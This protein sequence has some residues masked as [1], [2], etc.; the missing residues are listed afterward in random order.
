MKHFLTKILCGAAIMMAGTLCADAAEKAVVVISTDGTQRQET[1]ANVD[2]IE[3]GVNSLTLKTTSGGS[4][5]VAY[6]E[7]DRIL[8]GAEYSAIQQ[9]TTPDEVA[10]WPTVT[11]DLLNISGLKAGQAVA[12]YDLK[13]A[14]AL[15]AVVTDGLTTLSLAALPSGAYIVNAGEHSVKIIKK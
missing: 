2:R 11:S 14:I 7:L 13:G 9:I 1:L 10:V 3:I 8:V 15:K 6:N 5:T 4:Q 12:V